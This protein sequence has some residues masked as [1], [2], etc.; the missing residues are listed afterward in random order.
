[1]KLLAYTSPARGHL[2]P[3]VPILA[4]LAT[5]GH[6][7]S[8]CTLS[9]ELEH[10]TAIGIDGSAIDPEVENNQLEDWRERSPRRAASSVLRTFAE[11]ATHDAPILRGRSTIAIRMFS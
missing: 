4:V 3:I 9:G 6:R 10:I 1:M 7:V 5:R 11:R 2:Y 8:V